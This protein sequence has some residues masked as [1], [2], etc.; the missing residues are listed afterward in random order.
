MQDETKPKQEEAE[1][2]EERIVSG[3]KDSYIKMKIKERV[4]HRKDKK[5]TSFLTK[6]IILIIAMLLGYIAGVK[7]AARYITFWKKQQIQY[8]T[9]E[10]MENPQV[11]QGQVFTLDQQ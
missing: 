1:I 4:T 10:E 9:D 8:P 5:K 7:V 11:K 6:I 2:I 3:S